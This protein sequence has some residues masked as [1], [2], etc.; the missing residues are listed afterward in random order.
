MRYMAKSM[1]SIKK[2]NGS[3]QMSE[4]LPAI[5]ERRMISIL[6]PAYNEE[7]GIDATLRALC[8]DEYLRDAEIIVLDDGSTDATARV[9][10]QFPRIRLIRHPYNRG[11]GSAICTGARA[12]SG[13]Y[14]FWFD[15]DGQHRVA[16]LVTICQ[17]MTAEN[18][19]YCIGVRDAASYQD[20]DRKLG[21]W[22]LKQAVNFSVGRSVPDFNS[23]LRGFR[24]DILL[25]YLHLLP[26]GFGASTL[27]TLLMVE[28]NHYG[29]TVSINVGMRI[30]KSTVRQFQDGMR[31]LQII[32][33]I[34]LLFK[35][36]KFFGL[37]GAFFIL[38]GGVYGLFKAH[39]NHLGF[40]IFAS[41]LIILGVQSFFFGL[42][43]DQISA[44]RRERFN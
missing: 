18:L 24:R 29:S 1:H 3:D 26:K 21:K 17:R 12:S 28:G 36:L 14:I 15:A 16:D 39:I 33:H 9:V 41:L 44:L 20:P 25:R 5:P 38:V 11:Y 19:E 10:G 22:L 40:P 34:V 32:L 37:L 35:P 30:G 23:G 31:T 7:S 13:E 4:Y 6:I 8:A 42:L 27:T 43:G 2:V